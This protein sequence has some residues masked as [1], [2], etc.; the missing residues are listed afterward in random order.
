M[1]D[2]TPVWMRPHHIED[3]HGVLICACGF[4]PRVGGKWL[5]YPE[6]DAMMEQHIKDTYDGLCHFKR[7]GMECM[8]PDGHDGIHEERH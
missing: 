2:R 6:A 3:R 5:T 8:L 4:I 1:G 7:F